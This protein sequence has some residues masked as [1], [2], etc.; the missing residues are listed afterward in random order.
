MGKRKFKIGD[1]IQV[2][3]GYNQGFLG[4]IGV[5]SEVAGGDYPYTVTFGNTGLYIFA[6]KELKFVDDN[7]PLGAAQ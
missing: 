7:K 5:I 1:T 2:I 3:H 4:H 6:A